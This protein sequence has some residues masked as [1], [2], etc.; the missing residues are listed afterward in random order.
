MTLFP[1]EDEGEF[2]L[3]K[4]FK[5]RSNNQITFTLIGTLFITT[6]II[7][8]LDSRLVHTDNLDVTSICGFLLIVPLTGVVGVVNNKYRKHISVVALMMTFLIIVSL[9]LSFLHL[10]LAKRFA[11]GISFFAASTSLLVTI[12]DSIFQQDQLDDENANKI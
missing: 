11:L 12:S 10:E 5:N 1:E 3:K 9:G 4:L 8:I 7:A 6:V 2:I